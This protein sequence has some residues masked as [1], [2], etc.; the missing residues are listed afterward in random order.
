MNS[1]ADGQNL[2]G[3]M[4]EVTAYIVNENKVLEMPWSHY[5]RFTQV[6]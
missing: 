2:K 3:D 6:S 1:S 4:V 5:H